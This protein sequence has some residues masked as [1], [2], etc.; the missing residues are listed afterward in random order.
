[1]E[2]DVK[3]FEDTINEILPGLTVYVRDVNLPKELEDKYIPD[4]IILE[5][6]FTDVSSR[7]MGMKT[8]H[9]FAILS[10]HM[11]DFSPY[12][13]GTNWGLFVAN[14]SSHFLVLDKYEYHGKTQIML[15][16]L[17]NDKRWK[18]FQ[19]VKVNVLDN[20][21]KD[22]RQRFENKCEKEIIPE[23]ATEEWLD[24]CSTPL[25]MDD[26]GNLFDLDV[27]LA[28]RLRKIGETNFRNLYHQYI[29]IKVTP[30]FLK[31][32]CKSIDVRSEDDGIIAYGY[33]DDEAG[34]S[35]RVLCSANINNNKLSIGKYTKE[36]GIIIRK[37]QFNEFEYLDF[38]Y[39]D[40]DTTD[41]NEYITV[42]NDA[43]KC[44]NE[45]TEEM[46][47]FG[48]LDEVRSIDFPDDIQIILYQEG[49]NPEQV[50][51]KCWAF[52]EN[53]LF[54]KLLNEPNQ[55]FGV[56]NGSIIEFKPIENDDG[57]ICVYTGRWLEEQK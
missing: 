45:Q 40:V 12:E 39:C 25:G 26:N 22:T 4:T 15:L 53:E 56:H 42:I 55:D 3:L 2:F 6:G 37:G 20:I 44:K 32:L 48:F 16:H 54:A 50:W 38:D 9:R 1:M 35:F 36:V 43:Y 11:R 30:E 10:N 57:I 46:R 29:Y 8:T 27:I 49:L 21:I 14:S 47:N 5:R 7:V 23:L 31:G 51:G 28:H 13:H 17:P 19:N 24:R 52:T 41:F 18:L 34:F 33:I